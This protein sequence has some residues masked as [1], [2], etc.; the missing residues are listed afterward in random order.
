MLH[1]YEHLKTWKSLIIKYNYSKYN[2]DNASQKYKN[3]CT[4]TLTEALVA[5]TWGF[6]NSDSGQD[7]CEEEEGGAF[8]MQA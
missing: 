5:L 6:K 1:F 4:N 7:S 8:A 2:D 3:N